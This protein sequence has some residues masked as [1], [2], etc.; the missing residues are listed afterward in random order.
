MPKRKYRNTISFTDRNSA[1]LRLRQKGASFSQTVNEDLSAYYDILDCMSFEM[2]HFFTVKKWRYYCACLHG[3]NIYK[4]TPRLY[5]RVISW[6][7]K[8]GVLNN[9]DTKYGIN[10]KELA[11]EARGLSIAQAVWIYDRVQKHEGG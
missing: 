4:Y 8:D 6:A 1:R 2:N 7:L 3:I 5:A 10:A 9:L 11:K